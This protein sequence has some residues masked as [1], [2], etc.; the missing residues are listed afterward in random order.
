MSRRLVEYFQVPTLYMKAIEVYDK[1]YIKNTRRN[2]RV[3]V[4]CQAYQRLQDAFNENIKLDMRIAT[5]SDIL[6]IVIEW[7]G[8]KSNPEEIAKYGNPEAILEALLHHGQEFRLGGLTLLEIEK[9]HYD[10]MVN[11]LS[12]VTIIKRNKKYAHIPISKFLHIVNPSLFSIYDD[13]HMW[14]RV[15]NPKTH[16]QYGLGVFH[17]DYEQFCS[18]S[19]LRHIPLSKC[20]KPV[21]R[22]CQFNANYTFWAKEHIVQASPSFMPYF[23]EWFR[24]Q[25]GSDSNIYSLQKQAHQLHGLAFIVVALGASY[26]EGK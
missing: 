12:V 8:Q 9:V 16:S 15:M 3:D 13:K 19:S 22:G 24:K 4:K 25:V 5:I 7:M 21:E 1:E 20:M 18:C 14:H 26:I 23:G 10:N 17:R 6:Q 11:F 2:W